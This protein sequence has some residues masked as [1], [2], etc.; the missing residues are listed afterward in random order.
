M[1]HDFDSDLRFEQSKFAV[2]NSF[3]QRLYGSDIRIERADY[4]TI[5]GRNLQRKDIDLIIHL[6]NGSTI[7]VSEKH[8]KAFYGD[9]LVEFYSKFPNTLGWM[10]N[11]EADIMTYFIPGKVVVIDKKE[12]VNFYKRTLKQL[13]FDNTFKQLIANNPRRSA[14]ETLYIIIN[15]SREKVTIIQAYNHPHGSYDSWYTESVAISLNVLRKNDVTCK[16]YHL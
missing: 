14:K 10:D 4:D 5:S 9:I 11:S 1:T 12:L 16:E 13:P 8:R 3:Y 6:P 2:Q 7:S 15:G